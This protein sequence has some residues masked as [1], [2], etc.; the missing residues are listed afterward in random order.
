MSELRFT[1]AELDQII[2]VAVNA[3]GRIEAI[4]EEVLAAGGKPDDV[5]PRVVDELGDGTEERSIALA[6][7]VAWLGMRMAAEANRGA[8]EDVFLADYYRGLGDAMDRE[9]VETLGAVS[10]SAHDEVL[11]TVAKKH[12]YSVEYVRE[13]LARLSPEPGEG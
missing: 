7:V 4:M 2:E 3:T 9:G 11:A 8:G 5:F 13:L 1:Q 10:S 12:G 6:N